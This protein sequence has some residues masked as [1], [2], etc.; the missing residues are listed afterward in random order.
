MSVNLVTAEE[1]LKVDAIVTSLRELDATADGRAR[2][3]KAWPSMV[4]SAPRG[5]RVNRSLGG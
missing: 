4:S 1:L 5:V 2:G 3:R